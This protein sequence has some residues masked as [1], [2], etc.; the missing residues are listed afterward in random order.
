MISRRNKKQEE[1]IASVAELKE[2]VAA[3]TA[4]GGGGHLCPIC[5]ARFPAYKPY[6]KRPNARCPSCASSERHR[7]SWLYLKDRTQLFKQ[8]T[9]LLHF[10]P[11]LFL[12]RKLEIYMT[13]DYTPASYDPDK[14]GEGIDMQKLPFPDGTFDMIYCSHVLEHVP[15]DHLALRELFRV[16]KKG[17]LAVIMVPI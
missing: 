11:E 5:L 15:D 4:T 13:I 8:P 16:L 1:L 9:K 10:A 14:P 6:N 2:Q 12:R 17:G 7:V 3:L